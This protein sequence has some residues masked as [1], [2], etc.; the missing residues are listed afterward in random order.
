M[1]HI[2]SSR[3]TDPRRGGQDVRDRR[4]GH[5]LR[6]G[7]EC[8]LWADL[9]V[10]SGIIKRLD[11]FGQALFYGISVMQHLYSRGLLPTAFLNA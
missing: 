4:S 8:G 10:V 7:C 3:G 5:R 11:R 1:S 2:D 9:L 6:N